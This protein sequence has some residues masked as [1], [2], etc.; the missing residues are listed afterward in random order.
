MSKRSMVWSAK[1]VLQHFIR[2]KLLTR[3]VSSFFS[4]ARKCVNISSACYVEGRRQESTISNFNPSRVTT[5]QSPQELLIQNAVSRDE[6]FTLEEWSSLCE[7]IL[8]SKGRLK[9]TTLAAYIMSECVRTSNLKV[10]LS[11]LTY[12]E[13]TASGPNLATLSAFFKLWHAI[14]GS[15]EEKELLSRYDNLRK[16][17]PLLDAATSES[18]AMALSHTSRWQDAFEL[19]DM[20]KLTH[21][22]KSAV[23]TSLAVAAFRNGNNELAH[24]VMEEVF[25]RDDRRPGPE[26]YLAWL[27]HS[28]PEELLHFIA[29][30]GE[31][32]TDEVVCALSE[33]L[34]ADRG[35]QAN[36][37][38]VNK[39]GICQTCNK[40][41][42]PQLPTPTEYKQ[43]Q[44]AMLDR[45]LL[46]D[47]VFL[48]TSPKEVVH[49]QNMLKKNRTWDVVIDGLNVAFASGSSSSSNH[50]KLLF[51]VVEQFWRQG[52]KVLVLGRKHMKNW[53]K[54]QMEAL[55][56]CAQ[57]FLADNLSQDDPL[58]LL[59]ALHSGLGTKIVSRDLMRT[60]MFLL[61]DKELRS[62]FRRWQYS[63]Q[64]FF[65]IKNNGRVVIKD[66]LPF[67]PFAQ[68]HHDGSWHLPY[69]VPGS[70]PNKRYNHLEVPEHWLCLSKV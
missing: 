60:H 16:Q 70:S 23:Y 2:K 43:L 17:Y 65:E 53:P 26:A 5:Q 3:N 20:I 63:H 32:P 51:L 54:R 24:S 57:L 46:S 14:G 41:L 10:G 15:Y 6:S 8:V 25:E 64:C 18:A 59:A 42:T 1:L 40:Q 36:F 62:I 11:L 52:E 44:V 68:H 45:V 49:F 30:H 33:K 50:A 69:E 67:H 19:L 56:N 35:F 22:P 9:P 29:T 31:K 27:Q 34:E 55:S 12:L 13:S 4:G 66:P 7:E 37:T 47:D 61:K 38:T 58:V 39:R 48:K 21:H 28:D